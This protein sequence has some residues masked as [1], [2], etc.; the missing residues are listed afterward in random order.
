MNTGIR[1]SGSPGSTNGTSVRYRRPL[2]TRLAADWSPG[3]AKIRLTTALTDIM[4]ASWTIVSN[5]YSTSGRCMPS[6]YQNRLDSQWAFSSEKSRYG[7][8]ISRQPSAPGGVGTSRGPGNRRST[9]VFT[10]GPRLRS[11]S[12]AYGTPS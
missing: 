6:Q 1:R 11:A 3:T 8:Y 12:A 4:Y 9:A 5:G 2:S 10:V 7:E